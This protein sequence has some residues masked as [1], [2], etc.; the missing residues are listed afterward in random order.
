M[1]SIANRG[2]ALVESISAPAGVDVLSSV[3]R[4]ESILGSMMSSNSCRAAIDLH[5]DFGRTSIPG[6]LELRLAIELRSTTIELRSMVIQLRSTLNWAQINLNR[7]R[8]DDNR[9][10]IDSQS[11]N[12]WQMSLA[13]QSGMLNTS[14]E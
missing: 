4:K 2:H 8:I 3:L 1:R 10:P 13:P 11:V 7:A 6:R 14:H 12:K 9:A 5:I